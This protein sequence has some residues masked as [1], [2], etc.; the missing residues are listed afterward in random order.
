MS[1]LNLDREVR[2][3]ARAVR[4][5]TE[6]VREHAAKVDAETVAIVNLTAE[7][8][9]VADALE[10]LTESPGEPAVAEIVVGTRVPE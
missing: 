6:A 10:K 8:K 3:L 2:D 7:T 5:N 4:A 1:L 9:R